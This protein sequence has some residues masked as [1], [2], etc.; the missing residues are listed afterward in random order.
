MHTETRE[1]LLGLIHILWNLVI[2]RK[3]ITDQVHKL[4]IVVV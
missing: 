3:Y 2:L 4:L 1:Q